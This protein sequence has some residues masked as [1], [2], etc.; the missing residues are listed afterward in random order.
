[1]I[2]T[3]CRSCKEN[4]VCFFSFG[5]MPL[6]NSF[7][8]SEKGF[9]NEKK[10]DLSV[11]FCKNCYLVQ[12]MKTINPK[13]LFEDYIYFSSTAKTILDHSKKTA[14]YLTKRLHLNS[15]SLVLEIASND[16]VQ[17][18]YFKKL[19]IQ[20]LGI[21]PAKNIAKIANKKGIKTI[22]AFFNYAFAKKLAVEGRK[23]DL[24]LGANVLA[25]VPN[26]I[27]F[28]KG[29]KEILLENGTVVFEFPYL[30]GLLENKF[31][32]IY[33]EHVF[34]YSLLSLTNLFKNVDLEIYDVEQIA[35]QGGSMRI[36]ISHPGI[37]RISSRVKKLV[38]EELE[39]EFD[40]LEPYRRIRVRANYLKKSLVAS[41]QQMKNQ[42]KSIAAYS[43]P[44]KGMILLNYCGIARFLE[45]IVDKS[46]A[47][48]GCY[49]P[50][51]HMLVYHPSKIFEENPD[52]LLILCWN[53]AGEVMQE[54]NEYKRQ[55]GKF[56]I[57]IPELK[58]L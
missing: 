2:K 57:P 10:Y 7:L 58:V 23:T 22:P 11:G 24:V 36:F 48:Q 15:K 13:A 17:L 6:V 12:L 56:I 8:R 49:T 9:R 38:Q 25:H 39:E 53:I 52:F 26:I 43:A 50:G 47:K 55:G 3:K 14:A 18:Q 1:M 29:V 16:G 54:Y 34:Y 44:A 41:L 19:G 45:F 30:K 27:D 32:I 51:T 5:K 4:V 31:D 28:V 40:T 37:Y 21:D 33:H 42:G 35:A 46:P 20:I